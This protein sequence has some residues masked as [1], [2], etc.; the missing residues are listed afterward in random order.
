MT[1][2]SLSAVTL[3]VSDM[4][5]SVRF[6][7]A[8]G[9]TIRYGGEEAGFTSFSVGDSYLNLALRPGFEGARSWGRSIFYVSD[10][11][12]MYQRALAAGLKPS[13]EPRNAE[14]HERFFHILDPDGHEISFARPL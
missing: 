6:Y 10:V 1:I 14:W 2:E 11:D 3:A 4:G 12:A 8:L 5:L 9:F 13:T 7:S